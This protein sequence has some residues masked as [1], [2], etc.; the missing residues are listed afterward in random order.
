MRWE[1]GQQEAKPELREQYMQVCNPDSPEFI[2]NLPEYHG[3][4]TYTLIHARVS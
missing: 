2:L 1:G 3:F 4:F